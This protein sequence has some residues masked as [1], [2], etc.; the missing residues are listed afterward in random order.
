MFPTR[1]QAEKCCK[2]TSHSEMRGAWTPQ[3]GVPLPKSSPSDFFGQATGNI[4][5]A[6]FYEPCSGS[7]RKYV[8]KWFEGTESRCDEICGRWKELMNLNKFESMKHFYTTV[9]LEK[10]RACLIMDYIEGTPLSDNNFVNDLTETQKM[11]VLVGILVQ[12][13]LVHHCGL[14]IRSLRPSCVIVDNKMCP[15]IIGWSRVTTV[16]SEDVIDKENPAASDIQ[17]S[18]E[19]SGRFLAPECVPPKPPPAQQASDLWSFAMICFYVANPSAFIAVTKGMMMNRDCPVR[20]SMQDRVKSGWQDNDE[21]QKLLSKCLMPD[22]QDRCG[23][24]K[25]PFTAITLLN[26]I[27]K[28]EIGINNADWA[29]VC[30]YARKAMS[31]NEVFDGVGPDQDYGEEEEEEEEALE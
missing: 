7:N 24:D 12:I 8:M 31:D 17:F 29:V 13:A 18:D 21:F 3:Y 6:Y 4:G 30:D 16:S 14:V 19:F 26:L 11:K 5:D 15:H 1:I 20:T 23:E 27:L 22:P 25:V 28:E 9:Q 10:A 2:T